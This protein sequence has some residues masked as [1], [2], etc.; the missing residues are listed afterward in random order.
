M[1][2]TTESQMACHECDLL[3][4]VPVLGIGQ[5]A[6]CPRCDY[7]LAANRPRAQ[8]RVFAFAVAALFFLLL[9]NAFPFLGV[10]ASGQERTITLM[11]SIAILGAENFPLLATVVFASIIAIPGALLV[12]IIYVS[13]SFRLQLLLPLTP[14]VL[15][16]VLLLLPWSM[17]EIFLIGILVSFVKIV[18]IADVSLGLSFWAYV[19]FSVCMIAALLNMDKRELW[20]R[21]SGLADG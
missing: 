13:V 2:T 12:G 17:A 8:E 9:A 19:F 4:G 21:L 1:H 16:W 6:F 3:V 18:A 14:L 7:L 11:Q 5:K 15:R 20:Q 10:S